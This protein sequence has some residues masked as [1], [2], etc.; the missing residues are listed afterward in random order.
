MLQLCLVYYS[1][2]F[3]C[4]YGVKYRNFPFTLYTAVELWG[5]RNSRPIMS[6]KR[7]DVARDIVPVLV[8]SIQCHTITCEMPWKST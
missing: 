4:I 2:T 8:L 6:S 7:L 3:Y 1:D 5:K